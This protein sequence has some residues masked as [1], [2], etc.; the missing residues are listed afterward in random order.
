M[1]TSQRP[2]PPGADMYNVHVTPRAGADTYMSSLQLTALVQGIHGRVCGGG[3]SAGGALPRDAKFS[4][5]VGGVVSAA[6]CVHTTLKLSSAVKVRLDGLLK[7]HRPL[8][9][10]KSTI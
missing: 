8:R 5:G 3:R 4:S 2:R 6:G 1:L 10:R 9:G 7:P